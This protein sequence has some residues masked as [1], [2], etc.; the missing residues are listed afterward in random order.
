MSRLRQA[1][2]V[3]LLLIVVLGYVCYRYLTAE[4]RL[5]YFAEQWLQAFT[6]GE[7]RVERVEFAPASGLHLVGVTVATPDTGDFHPLGA[8][9]EE[10][11]VFSAGTVLFRLQPFSII[12]GDLIVPE[13]IAVNPRLTLVDRTSDG[14]GNWEGMLARRK[15][16]RP[17]KG[18]TRLPGIRLRNVE[19]RQYRL[20]ERG[21][22][23]GVVQ[24]FYA[25][26]RPLAD[27]PQVYDLSVTK[28]VPG[29]DAQTWSGEAG[30]L[31]IDM[32]TRAVSGS[33]PSLSLEELLFAA[34]PE[35]HRWLDLLDLGGYVRAETF[36]FDPK[37][38]T[39]ASLTLRDARL[40]IPI[41]DVETRPAPTGRYLQF[42]NVAGSIQFDGEAAQVDWQGLFRQSVM[43]VRG[44]LVLPAGGGGLAGLGFDLELT[45]TQVPLPRA[46]EHTSEP[47]K[48]FVRRWDRLAAFV[49]DFDGRGNVDLALKLH[50]EAGPDKGIEF[51]EGVLRPRGTSAAFR[52]FPYRLFDMAGEVR[53]RRDGKIDLVELTGT[54][55]GGRV[56]I[57][58]QL[59]GPTRRDRVRLDIQGKNIALDADLLDCLQPDDRELC[60]RF[61]RRA[62]LDLD[63]RMERPAALDTPRGSAAFGRRGDRGESRAA[64]EG[65][66]SVP[67]TS[68]VNATFLD[69]EFLYAGFPY[70]LDR[71]R[72]QMRIGGGTIRLND[73]TGRH[74]SATVRVSGTAARDGGQ[75]DGLDL[76]LQ[77]TDV[78]LDDVLAAALPVDVRGLYQRCAPTGRADINGR[79][80]ISAAALDSPR[81]PRRPKAAEPRGVS[82]A[83]GDMEYDLNARL[84]RADLSLPMT[85][86][87][88][89]AARLTGVDAELHIM[90]ERL[91]VRSL[92]GRLGD[93]PLTIEGSLALAG[94]G[95]AIS[96][97]VA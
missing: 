53:F 37:A 49:Y 36:H 64:A 43:Q 56:T 69:G 19:V 55:G 50:K 91:T 23:G 54:H 86:K 52:E 67:W 38:G 13:I 60:R 72:G 92:R 4:A 28:I 44:R 31:Q 33:L 83:G 87:S 18:R 5:R 26:A 70:P 34:P 57:N 45:A 88:S 46:D 65:Q 3:S 79:L 8:S 63:I 2:G 40:S 14:L 9:L 71:L 15:P 84:S 27:R 12:S 76:R 93:S 59:S 95:P 66:E 73:L 25:G 7:A 41:D 89:A 68:S 21:R 17:G 82:R 11:T 94:T 58:G 81:S 77:A 32:D 22:L 6:G 10:R 24:T 39:Q 51:V 16:G 96:V 20:N 97:R 75:A 90:P 35:I 48:R 42:S 47:E 29:Q 61:L 85:E 80:F 1:A 74:G 62:N 30:R 78:P